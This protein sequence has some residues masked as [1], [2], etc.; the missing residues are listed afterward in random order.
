[1]SQSVCGGREGVSEQPTDRPTTRM[2]TALPP[3]DRP[4]DRWDALTNL[5]PHA[6]TPSSLSHPLSLP[7]FPLFHFCGGGGDAT[8]LHMAHGQDAMRPFVPVEK[9]A[10]VR[11]RVLIPKTKVDMG[12]SIKYVMQLY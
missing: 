7:F 3:T 8:E 10:S 9:A 6:R 5:S 2:N 11:K 4:T 1:M 12:P